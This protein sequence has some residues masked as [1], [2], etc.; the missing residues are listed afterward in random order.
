MPSTPTPGT[1]TPSTPMPRTTSSSVSP[2]QVV[3]QLSWR[4]ATK[5]F[6]PA[7][8]VSKE[9]WAALEQSLVL[10]PSSFGLQPW[11]FVVVT[12]PATKKRLRAVS[13]NQSQVEDA[14][15]VVAFAIKKGLG[16]QDVKRWVLRISEVRGVPAEGLAGYEKMM[17]GF[18]NRPKDAFDADDWCA[19]QVYIALGQ[20]M[21]A[22]AMMGVDTCPME[23][24]DPAGYDAVLGLAAQGYATVV[25]CVAG[26]RAATDAF[27]THP[28]VRYRAEDVITHVR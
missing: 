26:H 27:A 23:G 19:R 13:W 15:H 14:S 25:A 9:A 7:K 5:Q 8:P 17:L 4:Y 28:K 20:F 18:V 1:P 21:A 6:D 24:L 11:R 12:D 16:T 10:A 22:A 2:S 3:Q